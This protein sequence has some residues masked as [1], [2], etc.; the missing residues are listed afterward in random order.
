M[1][2]GLGTGLVVVVRRTRARAGARAKA[3]A[4]AEARRAT[5]TVPRADLEVGRGARIQAGVPGGVAVTVRSRLEAAHE[6]K[7]EEDLWGLRLHLDT[8]H[9]AAVVEVPGVVL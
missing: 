1:G 5:D 9:L 3:R 6:A 2:L 4:G 8:R 7:A